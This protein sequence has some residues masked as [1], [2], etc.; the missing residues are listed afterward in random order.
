MA[1]TT[2]PAAAPPVLK[3]LIKEGMQGAD[4]KACKRAAARAGFPKTKLAGVTDVYTATDVANIK[5]FQTANGLDDD[6]KIGGDTFGALLPHMDA[7][8]LKI[9][10]SF[11]PAA[12]AV[13]A[14]AFVTTG[15]AYP[16]PAGSAGTFISG[17]VPGGLHPTRGL[18]GNFALDF[19]APGGTQVLAPEA[20]TILKLSGHDPGEGVLGADIFGLNIYIHTPAGAIYFATHLGDR[21][22]DLGQPVQPGDVIGHVGHWP[23]DPG[24]SHTHLGVTHPGGEAQAKQHICAVAAAPH[25]AAHVV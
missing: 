21:T 4:V 15:L 13:V 23:N 24:R 8:A 18:A 5:L 14:A 19:M 17:G 12:V 10:A 9:Y 2:T 11:D 3:R 20:G 1:G 6:G 25:V 7:L 16:H 22:V